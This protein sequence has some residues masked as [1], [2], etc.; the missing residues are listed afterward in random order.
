ML[1]ATIAV[2]HTAVSFVFIS[3]LP[4]TIVRMSQVEIE[5]FSPKIR[6]NLL[7]RHDLVVALTKNLHKPRVGL[8]SPLADV[9]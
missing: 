1:S 9:L 8:C 4:I 5:P 7:W 3:F 2:L 6:E